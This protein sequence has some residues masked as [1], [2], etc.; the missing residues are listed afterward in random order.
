MT[1]GLVTGAASGVGAGTARALAAAGVDVAV[2]D[3][4]PAGKEV[5]D[6][7]RG[8]FV[9]LDVSDPAAWEPALREIT[10]SLG[11]VD[12]AHLNAGMM[13]GT[14][15]GPIDAAMKLPSVTLERYQRV[16][17]VNVHGVVYGLRHLWE[18][19]AAAG[20]GA[21]VVTASAA[22]LAPYVFDPIY[23]MTKHALVG[24]VRSTAPS[25]ARS[26]VRLQAICPGAIDTPLMP[27]AGR[28]AGF[29]MLT[30]DQMGAAV[31]D[32]LLN[33][34]EGSIFAISADHPTPTP[35]ADPVA[36]F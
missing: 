29:P 21:I 26:G 31:T 36:T 25:L 9:S 6:D 19:M 13:T 7:C 20:H 1:V 5:A 28:T 12:V 8:I 22:G 30:P 33:A 32:L 18:P 4:S 15:N 24:L 27:E 14:P 11:P 3:I 10:T 35:V 17:G 23:S 16:L 34:R 2:C